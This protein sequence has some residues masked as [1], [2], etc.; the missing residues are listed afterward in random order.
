MATKLDRAAVLAAAQ[1]MDGT[2]F[3]VACG[4]EHDGIEPDACKY[5]CEQCGALAVYGAEEII[6]MTGFGG[7]E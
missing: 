4:A 5:T 3:C 7:A 1:A 6:M 2:G